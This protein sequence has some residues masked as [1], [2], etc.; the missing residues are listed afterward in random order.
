MKKLKLLFLFTLVASISFAQKSPRQQASGTIDGVKIEIDYSA[1]SVKGRTI[2]GGL[3]KYDKVWRAGADKN[4]TM[5]F[6][7]DV[8]IAGEELPA[9]KYGFFIIPK[10][11]GDWTIIFNTKNDAW[12]A[13]D[14]KESDDALRV[15]ITPEFGNEN[16]EQLFYGIMDDEIIFAW[17][18]AKLSIPVEAM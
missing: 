4:T 17:E 16:Q 7:T 6:D 9:G 13:Y 8:M 14:Y 12:G 3:E 10:K 2:W 11:D 5:S 18:K 15:D 1:P